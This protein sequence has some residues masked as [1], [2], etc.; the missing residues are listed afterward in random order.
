[1]GPEPLP[2]TIGTRLGPYQILALLGSGGMGDVHRARDTRLDRIVAIKVLK[3]QASTDPT[4]HQRFEREAKIV[5]QLNHPHICALFDV[6]QHEG[7]DYLV[8]EYL[9]GETLAER[10]KGPRNRPLSLNEALSLA[11]QIANALDAAHRRGIVHRDLK[12]SNVML[13][14][15][16]AKLLDFGIAKAMEAD[17][18]G[19]PDGAGGDV[20]GTDLQATLTDDG[21]LLGTV[22]YM[23]PEQLEGRE[24]DTRSD[25]FAFGAVLYEMLT[26]K[27]AFDGE[28]QSKVI[29]AV[30]DHDPPSIGSLQP[31]VPP[32][33][34][35]IVQKCLVKDPDRRWQ[36][37][38]DLADELKWIADLGSEAPT[39]APA[40]RSWRRAIPVA[41]GALLTAALAGAAWWGFRSAAAPSGTVSRFTIPLGEGHRFPPQVLRLVAISPDGTQIVY[42]ANDRLY[43]RS[44]SDLEARPIPGS[45]GSGRVESPVFSPD[46]HWIAFYSGASQAIKKIAVSGG[47]AVTL[48]AVPQP[49]GIS[50]G[51]WGIHFG[52]ARPGWSDR[53][54]MEISPDGGKPRLVIAVRNG[55]WAGSPQFLDRE[56][57]L[58]TF[59]E[60]E[61]FDRWDKARIVVQSLKSGQ[62][63]TLIEGGSDGRYVPSG[64]VVYARGGV[65]YG[66]PFDVRQLR[67]SGGPVPMLE[68]VNHPGAYGI[69]MWSLA[70]NGTLLY[71]RG[72]APST[73]RRAVALADRSGVVKPLKMPLAAYQDPRVSPD[74]NWIA[75]GVDDEREANVWIYD[76]AG[77]TSGRRLTY[78]GRNRLPVWS[79]DGHR[80]AF[81]SDREGDIGLFWQRA[82][83]TDAP[84]RLTKADRE[85]FHI[86]ESMS[87]NGEYLLYRVVQG[88]S[89]DTR[90]PSFLMVLSLKDRKTTRFTDG[91]G[92]LGAFSPDGRWIA[93]TGRDGTAFPVYVQAFPS[94]GVKHQIWADGL[95]SVWSKKSMELFAVA[96]ARPEA[97]TVTTRPTFSFS[98]P[99]RVN[100]AGSLGGVVGFGPVSQNLD[101]MPDGEHFL[102]LV[103]PGG[104]D[105]EPQI[106]V[107]LNWVDELKQRVA[108]R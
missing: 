91:E 71:V 77:T 60:G 104:N 44:M 19:G 34:A 5:S 40:P 94:T 90:R 103:N 27:R 14:K 79:S 43:L 18:A 6:G 96:R 66:I 41:I 107:V 102:V 88:P 30:L 81:Q 11:I 58:F 52:Q 56:T 25:I 24:A 87:P 84:E 72:P 15:A 70:D 57:V 16:G 28:S 106:Q 26:G 48:C 86:A 78:G 105:P 2:L 53:G 101:T 61:P 47:S 85:T 23:A 76:V 93:Y 67:T 64:H 9:E 39:P 62:R 38:S 49:L 3:A 21:A 20:T 59:L 1:M 97:V 75:V 50:W 68:G 95:Q 7:I 42:P 12:P 32:S 13:T 35:R 22:Q 74:G 69:A 99:V 54:I 51:L 45:E 46:G 65:V 98:N 55:E 8:M 31:L 83:G 37:A 108:P 10:L 80:I 17:R 100:L 89:P 92:L 63:T 73:E 36:S 33:L 29:A 82:D 4:R